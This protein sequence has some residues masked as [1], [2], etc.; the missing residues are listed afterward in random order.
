MNLS[1]VID[2]INFVI[3][4]SEEFLHARMN[5]D[6]IKAMAEAGISFIEYHPP[7][8]IDMLKELLR[9][10][11]NVAQESD[12]KINEFINQLYVTTKGKFNNIDKDWTKWYKE[13]E[14][15]KEK[16]E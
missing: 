5:L 1:E 2:Q 10:I 11:E 16:N 8:D 4:D 15:S 9:I 3:D 7:G 13:K 12:D 14:E 6:G